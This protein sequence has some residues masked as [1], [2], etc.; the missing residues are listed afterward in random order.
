MGRFHG[1]SVTFYRFWIKEFDEYTL[2]QS[3]N[4]CREVVKTI[5]EI[6]MNEQT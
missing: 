2:A 3:Q 5:A 1:G 6:N 4:C